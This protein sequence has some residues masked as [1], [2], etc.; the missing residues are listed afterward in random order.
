MSAQVVVKE[1]K[2]GEAVEVFGMRF[3]VSSVHGPYVVIKADDPKAIRKG[4]A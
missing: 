2:V 3:T 1:V 4:T